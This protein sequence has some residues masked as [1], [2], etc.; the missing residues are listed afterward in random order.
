MAVKAS[1]GRVTAWRVPAGRHDMLWSGNGLREYIRA[2]AGAIK[3]IAPAYEEAASLL[4]REL[5]KVPPVDPRF[6]RGVGAVG[7]FADHRIALRKM[8]DHIRASA[9]YLEEAAKHLNA[10]WSIYVGLYGDPNAK[11]TRSGSF[12]PHK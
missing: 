12:E 2:N 10:A 9:A 6:R 7:N 1:T 11:P 5:K 3:A 8:R 4:Y